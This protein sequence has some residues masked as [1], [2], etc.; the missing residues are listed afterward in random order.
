MYIKVFLPG[1]GV[2]ATNHTSAH[3]N[4]HKSAKGETWHIDMHLYMFT[5]TSLHIV[6]RLSLGMA[7]VSIRL[8]SH[9]VIFVHELVQK[10]HSF[11]VQGRTWADTGEHCFKGQQ[12]ACSQQHLKKPQTTNRSLETNYLVDCT[13]SF[14]YDKD[15]WIHEIW[16]IFLSSDFFFFVSSV[17][18]DMAFGFQNANLTCLETMLPPLWQLHF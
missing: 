18:T 12:V 9:M 1:L 17:N 10:P 2:A 3:P 11:P 7:S 8:P 13:K 15:F 6:H 16:N 4:S 14:I 5:S